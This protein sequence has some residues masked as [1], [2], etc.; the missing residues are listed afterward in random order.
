MR[1]AIF[2]A[3]VFLT[4]L[5]V[6]LHCL[7]QITSLLVSVTQTSP[8]VWSPDAVLPIL[9]SCIFSHPRS[10]P[11]FVTSVT[12]DL[13]P[14]IQ[15]QK[16]PDVVSGACLQGLHSSP[17]LTRMKTFEISDL[18]FHLFPK[19]STDSLDIHRHEISIGGA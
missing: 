17:Q 2:L 7:G 16:S 15:S 6:S 1:H 5:F 13:E 19:S 18:L 10:S 12:N 11:P 8:L 3:I 9:L 14:A 4:K